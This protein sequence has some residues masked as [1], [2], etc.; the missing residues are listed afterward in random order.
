MKHNQV[1]QRDQKSDGDGPSVYMLMRE[2]EWPRMSAII[3]ASSGWGEGFHQQPVASLFL[4]GRTGKAI[5][6]NMVRPSGVEAWRCGWPAPRR[7]RQ[8]VPA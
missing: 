1:F 3:D 6:S 2:G 8:K 4:A 7:N 5:D